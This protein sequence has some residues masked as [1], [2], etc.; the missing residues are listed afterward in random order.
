M[1]NCENCRFG[2][3]NNADEEVCQNE[4][5][6]LYGERLDAIIDGCSNWQGELSFEEKA[7]ELLKS[8][9]RMPVDTVEL[10]VEELRGYC[11]KHKECE[12]CR[13]YK[14]YE[15]KLKSEIPADWE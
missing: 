14:D 6:I 2:K 12:D 8:N 7:N 10:A 5:S 13:F 4:E 11:R 3:L 1:N 15:C 9:N